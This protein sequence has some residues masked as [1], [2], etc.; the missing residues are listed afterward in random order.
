M[1]SLDELEWKKRKHAVGQKAQRKRRMSAGESRLKST[2]DC[3]KLISPGKQTNQL[4]TPAKC[5]SVKIL[6]V[7][8]ADL[9]QTEKETPNSPD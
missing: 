3:M 2:I 9:V 1:S 8:A 7:R 6:E 4:Y 5:K